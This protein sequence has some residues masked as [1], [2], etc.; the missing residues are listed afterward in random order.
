LS[1]DQ[2]KFQARA[3]DA[4]MALGEV[5][6]AARMLADACRSMPDLIALVDELDG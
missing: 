2:L 6:G 1:L 3:R 5:S 4:S